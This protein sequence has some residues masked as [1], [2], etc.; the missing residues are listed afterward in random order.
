MI[1]SSK[2]DEIKEEVIGSVGNSIKDDIIGDIDA[3]IGYRVEIRSTSDIL[4]SDIKE[5]T[6]YAQVFHGSQNVTDVLDASR[7]VWTRVSQDPTADEIW[8]ANHIGVKSFTATTLDI[9]YSATYTCELLD[10]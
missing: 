3:M 7:F 6:V 4:S 9:W 10:A 2:G 1:V 8:N 5:T